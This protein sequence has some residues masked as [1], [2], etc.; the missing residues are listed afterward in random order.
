MTLLPHLV[1]WDETPWQAGKRDRQPLHASILSSFTKPTTR[2]TPQ[3][4]SSRAVRYQAAE[5]EE[6]VF[7]HPLSGLHRAPPAFLLYT[8][9]VR[10]A[11]RPYVSGVTA[12]DPAWLPATAAALCS[13]SAPLPAPAPFYSPARDAVLAWHEVTFGRHGWAMPRTAAPHPDPAERC[14]RFAAALLE[15]RVLPALEPLAGGLAAP[16]AAL[17]RPGARGGARV[18]NLLLALE[19]AGVDSRRSLLAALLDEPGFLLRE[20]RAWYP[21]PALPILQQAWAALL[22]EACREGVPA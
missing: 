11:K 21:A 10:T 16:P 9:L 4:Y 12:L 19:R 17:A 8:D 2:F 5:L 6:P 20:L 22:E 18:S 7:L 13:L 3:G 14:A 1:V 15:G